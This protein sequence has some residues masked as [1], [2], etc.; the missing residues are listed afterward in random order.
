MYLLCHP[1]VPI[2]LYRHLGGRDYSTRSRPVPRI[3][4]GAVTQVDASVLVPVL[5]EEAFIRDTVAAMRAQ[6]YDGPVEFLFMDGGSEDRTRELIDSLRAHGLRME[7]EGP[8][9]VAEGPLAGKTLVVTGT[10]PS[11]SREEAT[12]RIEVA[13]GKVTGSVSGRTDFLVAGSDP[14]SK[15]ERARETGTEVIDEQRLLELLG[16]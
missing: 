6:T 7:E 1:E 5:N 4:C 8:A 13:G 11:L 12:A 16:G 3:S 2:P 14:G 10:L 15:L 9:P